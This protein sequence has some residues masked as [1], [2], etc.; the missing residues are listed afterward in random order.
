MDPNKTLARMRLIATRL[1]THA[2]AKDEVARDDAD[3]LAELFGALDTW[4]ER[5]G[6]MPADWAKARIKT[7]ITLPPSAETAS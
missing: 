6:F 2:D 3:E 7:P 5:G 4:L 1:V